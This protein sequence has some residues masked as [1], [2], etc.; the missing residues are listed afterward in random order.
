MSE[1]LSFILYLITCAGVT[2]LIRL[3]PLMF[4]RKK[5]ENRFI[6]SF[7]HYVPYTVLTVMTIPAV[8]Y[9]TS[10]FIS[11]L[12]GVVTAIIVTLIKP[13]VVLVA[14]SASLAVFTCEMLLKFI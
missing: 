2:Y 7:L 8:F 3:L 9:S 13:N 10:C 1:T 11:A 14:A 4:C 12:C 5:I 6:C